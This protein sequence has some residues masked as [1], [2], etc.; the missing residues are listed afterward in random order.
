MIVVCLQSASPETSASNPTP[1]DQGCC[2]SSHQDGPAP[3]PPPAPSQASPPPKHRCVGPQINV[4]Q[5]IANP[6]LPPPFRFMHRQF[7]PDLK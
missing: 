6:I 7:C 5:R 4:S 3:C 2:R 1:S